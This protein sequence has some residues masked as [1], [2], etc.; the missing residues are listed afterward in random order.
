MQ[1]NVSF[2]SNAVANIFLINGYVVTLIE[3][4]CHFVC[5][6]ILFFFNRCPVRTLRLELQCFLS[7][8]RSLLRPCP[9]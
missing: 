7:Y 4:V 6:D 9:L 3:E 2:Y 8:P 1:K 5:S